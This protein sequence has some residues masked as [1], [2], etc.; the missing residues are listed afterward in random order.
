[1]AKHGSNAQAAYELIKKRILEDELPPGAKLREGELVDV[2]GISRTP[3]REALRRLHVEGFVSFSPNVG[4]EVA[5]YSDDDV[6]EIFALRVDLD[7]KVAR[8]AALRASEPQRE[9]LNAALDAMV[10]IPFVPENRERLTALNLEFHL[11]VG[12]LSGSPRL[13]RMRAGL[14]ELPFVRQTVRTYTDP[15][16]ERSLQHHA[17]LVDAVCQHDGDWAQAIATSHVLSVHAWLRRSR[18]GQVPDTDHRP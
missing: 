4:T 13:A 18:A 3:I 11:L 8:L 17:E 6:D 16:W 10:R 1:M 12:E 15:A 2:L 7:G 9:Q 5:R 14:I